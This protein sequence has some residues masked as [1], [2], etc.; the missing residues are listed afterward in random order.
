[1]RKLIIVVISFALAAPGV[2]AGQWYRGGTLN[3]KNL[4]AWRSSDDQNRLA[5]AAELLAVAK[6]VESMDQLRLRSEKLVTCISGHAERATRNPRLTRIAYECMRLLGF[7]DA[8]ALALLEARYPAAQPKVSPRTSA[9]MMRDPAEPKAE[10]LTTWYDIPAF[11][12]SWRTTEPQTYGE[13]YRTVV[14]SDGSLDYHA[15]RLGSAQLEWQRMGTK[16]FVSPG[17]VAHGELW[18]VNGNVMKSMSFEN[19]ILEAFRIYQRVGEE[20]KGPSTA[21]P[22]PQTTEWSTIPAECVD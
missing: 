11:V 9:P 7:A 8:R 13:H 15:G 19:G 6:A 3:D 4:L 18:L 21:P 14:L 16:C 22:P 2:S 10:A 5:S 17:S 1:M 12:G 20:S